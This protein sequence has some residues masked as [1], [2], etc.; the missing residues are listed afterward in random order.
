M[1]IWNE[2]KNLPIEMFALPNQRVC[3][4]VDLVSETKEQTVLRVK[5]PAALPSLEAVLNSSKVFKKEKRATRMHAEPEVTNVSYPKYKLEEA[6]G[7][8]MVSHFE[9]VKEEPVV[10]ETFIANLA[11]A[12]AVETAKA[13]TSKK[14]ASKKTKVSRSKNSK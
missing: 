8:L 6:E 1:S 4:H 7:Y 9:P 10:A 3:N 5:S 14:T 2:I 11:P 13:E 12:P